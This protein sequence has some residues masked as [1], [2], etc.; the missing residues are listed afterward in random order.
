MFTNLWDTNF[1]KKSTMDLESQFNISPLIVGDF[2][3][4]TFPD[5][6]SGPKVN[7]ERSESVGI[8]YQMNLTGVYRVFYP[9]TKDL[10]IFSKFQIHKD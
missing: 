7:K 2:Q 6:S 3:H 8:I 10:N 1:I 9:N 5:K 4:P